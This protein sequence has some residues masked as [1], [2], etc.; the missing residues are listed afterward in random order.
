[1]HTP[2]PAAETNGAF[3]WTPDLMLSRLDGDMELAMQLAAIFVDEYAGMVERLRDA[4][5]G[6]SAEEIRRAAHAVKG[7][8]SNFVEGGP[9]ASAFELETMGR[10]ADVANAPRLLDRLERE[11]AALAA[12]LRSF[13][14]NGSGESGR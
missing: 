11:I 10:N 12:C 8:I 6:G 7:S 14:S 1:M 5:A 4:V 9:T 2:P 13:H 3:E